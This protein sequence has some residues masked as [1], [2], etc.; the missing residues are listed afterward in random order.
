MAQPARSESK[1]KVAII[2][3]GPAGLGAA[4]EVSKKSF[5][6][7]RIYEKKLEVSEIGNGLTIQRNTW[8]MLE[9]MN[10]AQHLKSSDFFRPAD[11]HYTQ[12]RWASKVAMQNN[13]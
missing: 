5:I 12:H 3:T 2:G 6:E 8:K 7:W 4:I 11:G 13:N 1:L 10:A 9:H